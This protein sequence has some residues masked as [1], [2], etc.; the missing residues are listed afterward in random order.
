VARAGSFSAPLVVEVKA[1]PAAKRRTWIWGVVGGVAAAAVLGVGLG[2]G[3]T[4]GRS[5]GNADLTII[6]PSK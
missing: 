3:L 2:V 5:S 1:R 6:A 4:V